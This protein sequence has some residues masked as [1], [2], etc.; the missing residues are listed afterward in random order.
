MMIRGVP[1]ESRLPHR[2]ALDGVRGVAVIAVLLFHANKLAGGYL[3]VDLFFVLSGYL[4]TSLLLAEVH[5]KGRVHLLGFWARRARRLLPALFLVLAFVG[6]YAAVV[7]EPSELHRIRVDAFATL[8]YVA[9]WRFVFGHFDY[10]A[11]F[12]SPSPLDHTWSLAIEEQFYLV[13]PL[14]FAGLLGWGRRRGSTA[15]S[16]PNA[17]AR[18]VFW[19][20][21]A[22][23]AASAALALG[24]WAT[25]QN[26]TRIYYGTDTRAASI[27]L[28]AALGA[29]LVWKGPAGTPRARFALE[30]GAI[31]GAV[32][33]AVA[34]YRLS[35]ANLY[36][37]GLLVCA[38]A[39]VAVVAAAAHP[40]PGLVARML[41]FRPLVGL[42]VIS[43]GLYLWH[44]PI[45]LWL[46][47][48]RV[49]LDGWSLFVVR[50]AVTLPV[51]I[52]SF[53]LVERPIRRGAF[54]P[55]TLRWLTPLAAAGLIVVT[56]ITTAGYEPPIST[57]AAGITDP[58][59]AAREGQSHPGSRRLMVVGNSVGYFLAGD[60]F[61]GLTAKPALVTLNDAVWGCD[62]PTGERGRGED[63]GSGSA[64]VPCD[65]G[66]SAAVHLFHP[67]LVLMMFND[68]GAH[69][70]LHHGQWVTACDP[71]YRDWYG[72]SL[73]HATRVLAAR[74]ARVVMTTGAYEQVFGTTEVSKSETD[75]RNALA[76]E[77][78]VT[79]PAVGLV[80]LG[81]YV[82]P[83]RDRCRATLRGIT[84]RDDG[85][86]YRGPSARLI[87][88]WLL[89]RTG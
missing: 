25:S 62:Y 50:M 21:L 81:R 23:A 49:E 28:G 88:R 59:E 10:F 9:N 70:I 30:A 73:E 52:A 68:A 44:W 29:F 32:I 31:V 1:T 85:A 3:G 12:A 7:A 75:C 80:D 39:G 63:F 66:W 65:R 43:Y 13:W 19:V 33:L 27:L 87:A 26:A 47:P 36:R 24:L 55:S 34:W 61:T 89:L 42:G 20:S 77:F 40:H 79:H 45:Y 41:S 48:A 51:A 76:R 17:T 54:T 69:Q 18:R 74:G 38:V 67:D 53:F 56:L 83:A 57:A 78:A 11:L 71:E 6:L 16:A 84:L 8:A 86:H 22:L 5:A 4:I 72:Q 14:A 2:R 64:T 46:N 58:A 35:G 15:S 60:G 82:C 37:G